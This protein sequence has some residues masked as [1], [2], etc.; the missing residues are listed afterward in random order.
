LRQ[1]GL[2]IYE[3]ASFMM[4]TIEFGG[5]LISQCQAGMNFS[6]L[7]NA[8]IRNNIIQDCSYG[9]YLFNSNGNLICHNNFIDNTIQAYA[10]LNYPNTWNDD[11]PSGGNYWSDYNG[12]DLYSGPDQDIP[13]SDFI[14]DTPYVIDSNNT[15]RYPL[16]I[17]YE[18]E[19]PIITIISPENKT[20]SVN[21][22]PLTF[23]VDE[24]TIWMGYSLD[25]QANVTITGNTTLPDLSDGS[26]YVA[27]YANDTFGNMGQSTVYFMVDTIPPTIAVESPENK[28]YNMD[29]VPLT[30]T[31]DE[32]TSWI[33]YTLDS[34]E[35]VTITGNTTL[36][37]LSD[38]Y[39]NLVVYANDT[40]G[41]MGSSDTVYFAIDTTAPSI[42]ILSPENKTYD[43]TDLPLNFTVDEPVSWMAYSLDGQA[44]VTISGDVTLSG[45]SDGSHNIIVYAE[46]A[47]GNTGASQTIYF[48]IEIPPPSE[49][50]PIWIVVTI[51]IIV[52]A[53]LALLVYFTKIR[54]RTEVK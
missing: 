25:G 26:H 19:P 17:P 8:T 15:D 51:P 2:D 43:T 18:T 27:V 16:M 36:P 42:S 23:T 31:V 49:A 40:A 21:I 13:G 46:D 22:L 3:N 7:E 32:A 30:F 37:D 45:L 44:N 33:G 6:R 48:T 35:N 47:A 54:K 41:N 39:H 24:M 10:S 12:K 1:L 20:Y 38:G 53:A 52:I 50:F 11:Y 9:I 4:G 5:N 14:G 29:V 28:T 34:Q